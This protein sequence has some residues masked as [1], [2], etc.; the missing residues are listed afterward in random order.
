MAV[1]HS[2]V[3]VRVG[4]GILWVGG[5]AYPLRNISHVGQRVILVDKGAAWKR[6]ILRTLISLVVGAILVPFLDTVG[7]V[8][9][10]AVLALLVWRLVSV[11][12][13]P[14]LYGLVVNTS[15]TQRD[16]VWSTVRAE[17]DYLVGEVAKAIGQP[18]VAQMVFNVEH[19][20]GG[21]LIQQYG[22]G[23]VGKQQHSGSGDNVVGR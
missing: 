23:S 15:G 3:Q 16:A 10:L 17:I 14:P 2:V 11:I 5:E 7:V 20:V 19:A 4:D 13:R 22:A 1:N 8:I 6:F 18:D 21:D 9:L 12:S